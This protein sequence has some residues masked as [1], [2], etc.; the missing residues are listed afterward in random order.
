MVKE[1]RRHSNLRKPE[2][3]KAALS[4]YAGGNDDDEAMSILSRI[5]DQKSLGTNTMNLINNSND[6]SPVTN[7]AQAY[8]TSVL[9]RLVLND[10]RFDRLELGDEMLQGC[11]F[12]DLVRSLSCNNFLKHIVIKEN[13]MDSICNSSGSTD[14][15]KRNESHNNARMQ[16]RMLMELVGR[17]PE[18]TTLRIEFPNQIAGS[19]ASLLCDAVQYGEKLES[20]EVVGLRLVEEGEEDELENAFRHVK[21]LTKLSLCDLVIYKEIDIDPF[22]MMI[23]E[24]PTL[25]DLE[26]RMKYKKEGNMKGMF[27]ESLCES[28]SL[29]SLIFW[30]MV[31]DMVQVTHVCEAI[32][33]S[34]NIKR[35]ELWS[36]DLGPTFGILLTDVI[37][38]NRSLETIIISHVGFHGLGVVALMNALKRKSPCLIKEL[39]LLSVCSNQ[40]VEAPNV[41]K[42]AVNMITKLNMPI[43]IQISFN[44]LDEEELIRL[45]KHLRENTIIRK[46]REEVLAKRSK[47]RTRFDI[48]FGITSKY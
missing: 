43:N 5:R 17:L 15:Q 39:R 27:F 28:R 13:F 16:P 9:E 44:S 20:L 30:N 38:K 6:Q 25:S 19:A 35:L 45:D 14:H 10:E 23:A 42:S 7:V 24:L 11:L 31:L 32:T 36:C 21:Q 22:F 1:N 33:K 37:T 2:V 26:I 29:N 4:K 18:L 40:K 3:L 47:W 34:Y 48:V 12:S 41:C 8:A 46:R